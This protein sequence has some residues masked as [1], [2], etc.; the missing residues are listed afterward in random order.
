M[1]THTASASFPC[2]IEIGPYRYRIDT[3]VAA[4][5][6]DIA[7][8]YAEFPWLD[9][10]HIADFSIQIKAPSIIRKFFRRN[11]HGITDLEMPFFPVP[12]H[13]ALTCLEM[14]IN[15]Q[16]AMGSLRHL[17]LHASGV[18]RGDVSII[19]P[20]ESG[21]GKST[22]AAALGYRNG[23]RFMGDEFALLDPNTGM[24]QPY[25]RPASLKNE[26]IPV[27]QTEAPAEQ[28]SQ[29]FHNTH[30]GTI[31]FIKPQKT[32]IEAMHVQAKP[33]MIVF[34]H[35]AAN[36]EPKLHPLMQAEAFVKLVSGSANY[37]RMG[38][39]GFRLLST[40]VKQCSAYVLTYSSFD[41]A[42]S[43]LLGAL[44]ELGHG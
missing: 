6:R 40:V 9:S 12:V 1:A 24:H 38:E 20:G 37:D 33:V 35:F 34:P 16:T 36:A 18:A 29:M 26:S 15:W 4:L 28:F 17:I 41:Q 5:R 22:L 21:S 14:S 13:H 39:A 3:P 2:I 11:V 27:M 10:S 42:E 44:K 31:C 43:L 25:P 23:W 7:R 8:L 30:K 32:A 19:M